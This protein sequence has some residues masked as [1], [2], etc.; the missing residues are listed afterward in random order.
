MP[1]FRPAYRSVLWFS[2][3]LRTYLERERGFESLIP[4]PV[5]AQAAIRRFVVQ[6]SFACEK[7]ERVSFALH[8]T[9]VHREF[10]I[11]RIAANISEQRIGR[12][13]G[14]FHFVVLI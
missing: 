8:Q 6:F 11:R 5:K 13:P 1:D 10:L 9:Q 7:K 4:L 14:Q 12:Q 3:Q 2:R